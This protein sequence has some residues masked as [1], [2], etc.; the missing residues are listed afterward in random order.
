MGGDQ[1]KEKP[2]FLTNCYLNFN[3]GVIFQN[4]KIKQFPGLLPSDC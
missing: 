3:W 1:F 2:L 4:F